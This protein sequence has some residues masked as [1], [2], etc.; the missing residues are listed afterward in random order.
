[1]ATTTNEHAAPTAVTDPAARSTK[2]AVSVPT[3]PAPTVSLRPI[4]RD[5]VRDICLLQVSAEQAGRVAANSVSIAE[6]HFYGE[7]AWFRAIYADADPIGFI[8]MYDPTGA[9]SPQESEFY[10]W[11]LMIDQRFQ[12]RGFGARAVHLLFEFAY[13]R[14]HATRIYVSHV[15]TA[16]DLGQ[17]YAR[18][19]FRYTGRE[20][21]GELFMTRGLP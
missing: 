21:D 4:T 6:G 17:W 5:T 18:L 19:G 12:R 10:L 7:E 20:E 11:R 13:A 8:M 15:K 2:A 14:R 3:A 16:P 9:A 1:M